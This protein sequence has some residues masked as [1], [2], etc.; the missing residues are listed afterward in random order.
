VKA[1]GHFR[2][3]TMK[4]GFEHQ[5]HVINIEEESNTIRAKVARTT[6]PDAHYNVELI[7]NSDRTIR[8]GHC[9]CVAG[10]D[11]ICKHAAAVVTFINMERCESRTD[12][13]SQ[14]QIPSKKKQKLY[15]KGKFVEEMRLTVPF[16]FTTFAMNE[17]FLNASKCELEQF[18]LKNTLIYKAI[19]VEKVD[20]QDP[21]EETQDNW[22]T[23]EEL[24]FLFS[25][26]YS[27]TTTRG[28]PDKLRG[29]SKDFF[30]NHIVCDLDKIRLIFAKTTQQSLCKEWFKERK[31]RVSASRAHK[32]WK[33]R[34]QSTLLSYFFKASQDLVNLRYGREMEPVARFKYEQVTGNKVL[35]SGLIVKKKQPWLCASPDG[36][37]LTPDGPAV[38]EI[39]CPISCKNKK[40]SVPYIQNETLKEK[41]E[42]YTQLQLQMYCSS[43]SKAHFFVYSSKD[44][45]LIEVKRDET[46]L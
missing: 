8:D 24:K 41:H 31:F 25:S 2:E 38:L 9:S 19:T 32:L 17:S 12:R 37:V 11:G 29:Q 15:P 26:D 44:F 36:I 43:V 33:A 28:F 22:T 45:L 35:S 4:L 40:I 30:E 13:E 6:N 3:G 10:I 39:K 18:G 42:Y 34:K 1:E 7:L 21:V 5:S 46:F 27:L 23:P 16:N 20:E 14:W